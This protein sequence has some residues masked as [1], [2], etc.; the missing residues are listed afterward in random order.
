M[1]NASNETKR[2]VVYARKS[3]EDKNQKS[4]SIQQ[5]IEDGENYAKNNKF[6][7]VHD[8]L[9]DSNLSGK[10]PPDQWLPK[11]QRNRKSRRAL[12]TLID[13]IETQKIDVVIVRK[14]DRL[15]RSMAY[16]AKLFDLMNAKK[17][18]IA[19][20]HE[21]L[22]AATDASG[23]FTMTMLAAIA[24]FEL[25]KT[26]ENIRAAKE[27]SK[28]H[29][30]KMSSAKICAGY[31]DGAQ[32][33]VLIEES[34]RSAI[35]ELFK[36]FSKGS[37]LSN[38]AN[39]LNEKYPN[40]H[41]CLGKK[42]YHSSVKKVLNSPR[43]IGKRFDETK[44]L[45]PDRVYPKIISE[46]LWYKCQ[47]RLKVSKKHSVRGTTTP[48]L[49]SGILRCGY[50]DNPMV[51]YSRY[52][53]G[54]GKIG[55]EFK[56]LGE[57]D[58]DQYA[59]NFQEDVLDELVDILLVTSEHPKDNDSSREE[60][61]LELQL[62]RIENKEDELAKVFADPE[63]MNAALLAKAGNEL[64]TKK[65]EVESKLN[66]LKAQRHSRLDRKRIA[67]NIKSARSLPFDDKKEL[68][69]AT[70]R[71]IKVYTLHVEVQMVAPNQKTLE[72]IYGPSGWPKANR[73]QKKQLQIQWDALRCNPD[74]FFKLT[75]P[76]MLKQNPEY[77]RS[78]PKHCFIPSE[79][80]LDQPT[81]LA[82][83]HQMATGDRTPDWS[84]FIAKGIFWHKDRALLPDAKRCT[85]C[86]EIKKND[87]FVRVAKNSDGRHGRCKECD[88]IYRT[89][90]AKK[91]VKK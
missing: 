59:A 16:Q 50:C 19:A 83:R 72:L 32:G 82:L 55:R 37:N 62:E 31:T 13:L 69:A 18:A 30:L 33:E 26:T 27:Y 89:K 47:Q 73:T 84:P 39:H 8:P 6:K 28:R 41:S 85:R 57:H 22:P 65:S 45:V 4:I 10:L 17:V 53:K 61:E 64:Q 70:V 76:V 3:K 52:A 42:W 58:S 14:L 88:K 56:C 34:S 7:I 91:R 80:D 12:S 23:V 67:S 71:W 9:V 15:N 66:T 86:K 25:E 40:S 78:R 49:T 5:Q 36:M 11:G 74:P 24:Q 38:I 81:L 2:A 29:N 46:D 44:Q 68:L 75:F 51:T 43:Y 54:K 1:S 63:S 77:C 35:E 79:L 60:L 87:C 48:V 90:R 21:S 20:T